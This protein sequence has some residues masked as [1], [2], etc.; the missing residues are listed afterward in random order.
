MNFQL[1]ELECYYSINQ[2][3]GKLEDDTEFKPFTKTDIL[4]KELIIKMLKYEDSIIH[5]SKGNEIYTN[6]LYK[7]TRSLNPEYAIHR[8][9][10]Q[11][12]GFSTNDTDVANYRS[13]FSYYY[14]S[15]TEYDNDVLSSVT[16]MRENKCIYYNRPILNIGD[17]IPDC[18][19]FDLD[20]K[21]EKNLFD[22]ID[23]DSKYVFIGAFSNS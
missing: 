8:L 12:F 18:K 9:V 7:P 14:T 19:L 2:I 5:G 22:I 17:K 10:L 15:P 6:P 21:T 3:M 20:G 16:Y 13:I 4:N 1:F 23:N 11:N